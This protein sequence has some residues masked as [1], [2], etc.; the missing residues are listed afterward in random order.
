ILVADGNLCAPIILHRG[1]FFQHITP[2]TNPFFMIEEAGYIRMAMGILRFYGITDIPRIINEILIMLFPDEDLISTL[3]LEYH[4]E[5]LTNTSLVPTS[6][7]ESRLQT[8][9]Q[10]REKQHRFFTGT[11]IDSDL[12]PPPSIPPSLREYFGLNGSS[13]VPSF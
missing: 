11:W 7:L 13:I 12:M 8:V 6:S 3:L 10:L 4:L 9:C 5:D 2:S 1:E